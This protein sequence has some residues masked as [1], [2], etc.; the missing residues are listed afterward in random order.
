MSD[1]NYYVADS[2][3]HGRGLFASRPI[4]KGEVIGVV[5]GP[6]TK[7]DGD[8]VLWISERT[9]VQME[10]NLRYVNHDTKPNICFYDT[11][12]AVALRNIK[13]DEEITHNYS[14]DETD[15]L[16]W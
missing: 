6:K 8:H 1:Q 13:T 5:Q 15:E 14:I 12:E 7:K 11:R 9:A 2:E 4:K 3:I 16:D 10:C